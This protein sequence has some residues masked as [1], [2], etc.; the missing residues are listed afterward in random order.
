MGQKLPHALRKLS[1]ELATNVSEPPLWR[2]SQFNITTLRTLEEH[3]RVVVTR[4]LLVCSVA[5]HGH[6]EGQALQEFNRGVRR[7]TG[8]VCIS[9]AAFPG[10]ADQS[11]GCASL[12]A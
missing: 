9:L 4:P 10:R 8:S 2:H 7:P 12:D 11:E 3:P 1:A 5:E 6:I